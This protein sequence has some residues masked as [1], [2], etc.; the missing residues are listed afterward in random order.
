MFGVHMI[1]GR[2]F[3]KKS[4]KAKQYEKTEMRKKLVMEDTKR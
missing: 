1:R 2:R 4:G 3:L